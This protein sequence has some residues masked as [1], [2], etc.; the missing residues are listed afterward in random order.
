MKQEGKWNIMYQNWT[1]EVLTKR[2][3]NF[4]EDKMI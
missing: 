1:T 3:K 2:Q 4:L